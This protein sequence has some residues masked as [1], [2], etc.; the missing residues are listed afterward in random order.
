I[1]RTI[2]PRTRWIPAGAR[3]R[4]RRTWERAFWRQLEKPELTP[5]QRQRLQEFFAPDVERL[6]ALSGERFANWS[7]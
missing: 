3:A 1:A 7:L 6:R 2:A 4:A 5:Q